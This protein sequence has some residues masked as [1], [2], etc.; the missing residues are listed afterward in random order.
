METFAG[1]RSRRDE[2]DPDV[3]AAATGDGD[4]LIGEAGEFIQAIESEREIL[5]EEPQ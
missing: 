5:P 1:L 2:Y 4:G 3:D